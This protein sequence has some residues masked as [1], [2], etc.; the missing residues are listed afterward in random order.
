MVEGDKLDIDYQPNNANDMAVFAR[1]ITD[2]LGHRSM[3]VMGSLHARWQRLRE[4]LINE[5]RAMEISRQL[6]ESKPKDKAIYLVLQA[7][8]CILHLENRVR[9]KSIESI[10]RSGLSNAME[11]KLEWMESNGRNKRQQEYVH[12][13]SSIIQTKILTMALPTYRR[14]KH[15]ST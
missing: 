6:V 1:Q 13:M 9:L 4:Q 11:G 10:L 5:Q 15:G 8:V 7:V 2:E 12:R 14:R 3:N